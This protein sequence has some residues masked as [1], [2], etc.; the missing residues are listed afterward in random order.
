MGHPCSANQELSNAYLHV[1]NK[2][3]VSELIKFKAGI[4][5]QLSP[6]GSSPFN[7]C[8]KAMLVG[9]R[10]VL[11]STLPR[12]ILKHSNLLAG[13]HLDES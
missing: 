3:V 9:D 12:S 7:R 6:I 10:P 5:Q 13:L 4:Q 2:Q 1:N 8:F 11:P